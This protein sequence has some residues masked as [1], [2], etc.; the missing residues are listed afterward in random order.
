M[1]GIGAA[2]GA[3]D[4]SHRF[5]RSAAHLIAENTPHHRARNG[6]DSDPTSTDSAVALLDT[7]D[8]MHHA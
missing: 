7:I 5:S 1:P 3:S 6:T 4:G 2:R 8:G